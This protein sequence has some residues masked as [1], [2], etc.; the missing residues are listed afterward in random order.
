MFWGLDVVEGSRL[1]YLLLTYLA[2]KLGDAEKNH[3]LTYNTF[4][5][6]T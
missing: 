2:V 6:A 3:G 1:D 5:R 4:S